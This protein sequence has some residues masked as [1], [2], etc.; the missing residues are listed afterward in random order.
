MFAHFFQGFPISIEWFSLLL[1][2]A[3]LVVFCWLAN[4]LRVVSGYRM[5]SPA[6]SSTTDPKRSRIK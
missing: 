3:I 6:R 4:P 5:E 2:L 1:S